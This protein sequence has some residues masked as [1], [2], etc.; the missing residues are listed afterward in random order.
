MAPRLLPQG[1]ATA[2]ARLTCVGLFALVGL[3]G[4][5]YLWRFDPEESGAVF[6]PCWFHRLSGLFCPGC[7]ATR[8]GHAL[9]HGRLIE[10]ASFNLF[11]V[12]AAVIIP[13][14]LAK[15]IHIWV[16]GKPPRLAGSAAR[17]W[18]FWI[19][20][21]VIAFTIMRNLPWAPFSWLAP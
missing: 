4:T 5:I 10:A 20:W 11:F 2:R 21:L 19:P 13:I 1:L 18:M 3:V 17:R 12:L 16:E 6:A 8:S 9:L 7:G 15:K 14:A